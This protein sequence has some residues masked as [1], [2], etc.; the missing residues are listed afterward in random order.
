M[1]IYI[2]IYVNIYMYIYICIYMYIYVYIYV[3]IYI[4]VY[5]CIYMYIYICTYIYTYI[6][7]HMHPHIYV[8]TYIHTYIHIYI[9]TNVYIYIHIYIHTYMYVYIHICTHVYMYIYMH[10][11]HHQSSIHIR[12]ATLTLLFF[13]GKGPCQMCRVLPPGAGP[14]CPGPRGQPGGLHLHHQHGPEA[15]STLRPAT[16]TWHLPDVYLVTCLEWIEIAIAIAIA[17]N[18]SYTPDLVGRMTM[19]DVVASYSTTV[20]QMVCRMSRSPTWLVEKFWIAHSRDMMIWVFLKML[21]LQS[22]EFPTYT[23]N[24]QFTAI[25][26]VSESRYMRHWE[27]SC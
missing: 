8:Y 15:V 21:I 1:Y 13:L 22:R 18:Q 2:Y 14:H 5:I 25:W 19:N 3:Y 16:C 12:I 27:A 26:S 4:H 6:H 23:Y 10:I 20:S 7:T 11:C 17:E 24:A 9:D